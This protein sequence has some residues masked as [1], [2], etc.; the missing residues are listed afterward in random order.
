MLRFA[1]IFGIGIP[2]GTFM[3]ISKSNDPYKY[4]VTTSINCNNRCFCIARD[5][6]YQKIIPLRLCF[7]EINAGSL[8]EPLCNLPRFVSYHLIVF[9]S[10]S[11]E[12]PF[13]SNR[14]DS[15]RCGYHVSKHFSLLKRVKLSL[16]CFFPLVPA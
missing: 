16:N 4:A 13:E 6:K 1:C 3:Y 10:L 8:C 14:K 15:G 12:H 2:S 9:I 7:I 5:I 11:I